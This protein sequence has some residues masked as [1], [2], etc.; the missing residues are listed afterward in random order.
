MVCLVVIH[1]MDP[2]IAKGTV[3]E[4]MALIGQDDFIYTQ[5][6]FRVACCLTECHFDIQDWLPQYFTILDR[7]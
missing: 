1:D 7:S 6:P 2:Q 3:D 5:E 4:Y